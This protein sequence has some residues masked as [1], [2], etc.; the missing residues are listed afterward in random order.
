MLSKLNLNKNLANINWKQWAV[1]LFAFGICSSAMAQD[2]NI[3]FITNIGCA[4]VKY[5][6]GPLAIIIFVVVL[7]STLVIG[8]I[9]KMDWGRIVALS[10]TFGIITAIGGFLANNEYIRQ[11]IGLVSCLM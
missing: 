6:K 1:V 8:L 10:V 9:A 5:M 3:P 7:I 11:S 4:I 2:F